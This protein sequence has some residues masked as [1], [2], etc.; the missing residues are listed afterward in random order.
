[1]ATR[2]LETMGVFIQAVNMP[3][4]FTISVL[5]PA[6]QLPDWLRAF[7]NRNPLTP[8]TEGL[9]EAFLGKRVRIPGNG[10]HGCHH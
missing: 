6:R 3:L 1:M 2:S 4:L 9:R 7:A 10:G 5:V 8:V